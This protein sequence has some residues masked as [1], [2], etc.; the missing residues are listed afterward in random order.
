MID[1]LQ[2]LQVAKSTTREEVTL[3]SAHGLSHYQAMLK[4]LV[5]DSTY[6][7]KTLNFIA[8]CWNGF[9]HCRM[10]GLDLTNTAKQSYN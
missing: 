2:L 1:A 3:N 4:Q 5:E 6:Q 9:C 8:T 10:F 7:K